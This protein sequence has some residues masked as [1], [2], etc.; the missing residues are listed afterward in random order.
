[1]VID[2]HCD[3]ISCLYK[4]KQR[5]KNVSLR[6][7]DGYR[8]DLTK[9][10]KGGYLLQNFA[11]FL[12]LAETAHPKDTALAMADLFDREMAANADCIRQA[13]SYAEI[14]ANRA[15]HK[16]S[17]VL[18]LEEGEILEGSLKNLDLFYERGARMATLTWNYPNSL[19]Y[20]NLSFDTNG[21]PQFQK[22]CEKG[23][24][25]LGLEMIQKMEELGMIIDVSHLSDGGFWDVIHHTKAPFVASHSNAAALCNVCRNLTD[26]MIRALS[27]RG[28]VIGLNYCTDF[29]VEPQGLDDFP[30]FSCGDTEAASTSE[31]ISYVKDMVRHARYITNIGGMEVCGLGSDFDGIENAVEFK[32]ASGMELLFDALK[33]GGFTEREIDLIFY[34]NVLRLY[35]EVL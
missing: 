4:D 21:M 12:D 9:L 10:Q 32:D 8:V 1:M 13:R 34:Q 15:E 11:L 35:R 23:L 5:G 17:A 22:R 18:T 14:E 31:Q 16:M 20:P 25:P 33:K 27:E 24:T 2:M 6:S 26:D 28:G 19:G 3:T 30:G 29:L 7:A